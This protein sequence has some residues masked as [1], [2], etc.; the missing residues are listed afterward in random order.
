MKFVP[1]TDEF[2]SWENGDYVNNTSTKINT[3][4]ALPKEIISTKSTPESLWKSFLK[5]ST[6]K[7]P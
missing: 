3:G 5:S 7:I 2:K 6:K 4:Q 1:Y